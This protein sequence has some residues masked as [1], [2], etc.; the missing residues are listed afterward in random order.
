MAEERSVKI[1]EHTI[2]SRLGRGGMASVYLARHDRLGRLVAV[3]VIDDRFD[4]D[5]HFRQRF[6][7][8]A[9]TAA[10]LTHPNIVPVHEYGFTDDGRPFLTLAF[11]EGGSLRDRLQ[12]RGPM[13]VDDALA[14]TRQVAAALLVAH[15][16]NI[17]HRD[18]KPDNVLFQGDTALLTDFGIAKVLDASTALTGMGTNPGTV[19]YFSPEQAR[20][21][22]IDQRSD[23]YTL[24]V[25]LYE[26]LTGHIPIEGETVMQLIMGIAQRAPDPLP[27]P[28]KGLQ[29]FLDVMLAKDPND[30]IGSCADVISIIQAMERNWLRFGEVDRLTDGVAMTTSAGRPASQ[31]AASPGEPS[32][33]FTAA[34]A[35]TANPARAVGTGSGANTDAAT[36]LAPTGDVRNT[37][38]IAPE[39]PLHDGMTVAM[40]PARTIEDEPLNDGQTVPMQRSPVAPPPPPAAAMA[41]PAAGTPAGGSPVPTAAP[42]RAAAAAISAEGPPR[43]SASGRPAADRPVPGS[44]G[45][46]LLYTSIA[47]LVLVVLLAGYAFLGGSDEV[48]AVADDTTSAAQPI[49]EAAT[50][51]NT[52]VPALEDTTADAAADPA[53][54]AALA[55]EAAVKDAEDAARAAAAE[56]AA[57]VPAPAP[58]VAA[59]SPAPERPVRSDPA[60]GAPTREFLVGNWE[61]KGTEF[62]EQMHV[63][64]RT[65]NDG[66]ARY[67]LNP[68]KKNVLATQGTWAYSNGTLTEKFANG[69]G[70]SA[71]VRMI[72]R[73][74][75]E[76]R[77]VNNGDPRYRGVTR[78]YRR[79]D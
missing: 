55:A 21:Q 3:K 73:T 23:I 13:A 45:N 17:V 53:R 38:A 22:P 31:P 37:A 32:L 19:K 50:P 43:P 49:A 58:A 70:G 71:E 47:A 35:T 76:L 24:G 6:E 68:G 30:R 41:Q 16:R 63:I 20:E 67:L 78:R 33:P 28:L 74:E 56:A 8:E 75:F 54:D 12:K 61:F 15:S 10:G 52:T 1:P 2:L 79:I 18:L 59:P 5:E 62:G 7:R 34:A 36:L 4:G 25:V 60:G 39:A 69:Q 64:W 27:P 11:L 9:R 48:D 77:I 40:P 51:A 44:I 26:M 46:A 65:G 42:Q 72:S 57:A 14:V 29:P 66:N